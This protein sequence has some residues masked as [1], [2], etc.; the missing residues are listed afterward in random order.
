MLFCNLKTYFNTVAQNNQT[1]HMAAKDIKADLTVWFHRRCEN[2]GYAQW[3]FTP[4]KLDD[5]ANRFEISCLD[6]F[7]D[8]LTKIDRNHQFH[9]CKRK[10]H[11]VK[12]TYTSQFSVSCPNLCMVSVMTRWQRMMGCQRM[13][14]CN[15]CCPYLNCETIFFP[16]I[17]RSKWSMFWCLSRPELA[18]KRDV[19]VTWMFV[20]S[21]WNKMNSPSQKTM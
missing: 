7:I 20:G 8:L 1:M 9:G 13:T 2:V 15:C 21:G 4:I 19:R 18:S 10:P 11:G 5:E 3:T 17:F 14:T 6:T 16:D 12:W